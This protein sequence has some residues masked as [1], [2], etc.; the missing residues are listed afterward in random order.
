MHKLCYWAFNAQTLAYFNNYADC[1]KAADLLKEKYPTAKI[2]METITPI[3]FDEFI[4]KT[5]GKI[6]KYES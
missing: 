5:G 3:C 4:D 2:W 6:S 1:K